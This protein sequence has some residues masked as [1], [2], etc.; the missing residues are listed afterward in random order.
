MTDRAEATRGRLMSAALEVI[1]TEGLPAAS[2]RTVARVAQANQALIFYH[3]GTLAGLIEAASNQAVDE[4]VAL[5]RSEFARVESLPDL[6]AVGRAVHARERRDGTM[7]IMAQLMAGSQRDPV[8]A[9]ATQYAISAWIDEVDGVLRRVFASSPVGDLV[10]STGL[11]EVISATFVG[12]ELYH[13]ADPEAATRAFAT[14]E[15]LNTLVATINELGITSQTALR[16]AAI[17]AGRRAARHTSSASAHPDGAAT[18][19]AETHP[20]TPS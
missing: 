6:L 11:A 10:D 3:F 14:I 20:P 2:A 17:R 16:I 13:G 4:R 1:R 5:Y 12:I 8:L 18:E 7:V 9:R 19:A 15:R